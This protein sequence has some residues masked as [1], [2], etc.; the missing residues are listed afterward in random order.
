MRFAIKFYTLFRKLSK[1]GFE[2][3]FLCQ[4]R[5]KIQLS[6]QVV[7]HEDWIRLRMECV[8]FNRGAYG[9]GGFRQISMGAF[10][11]TRR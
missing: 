5:F 1:R 8:L 4:K 2:L 7:W 11:Q 10:E 3:I 9:T 6:V